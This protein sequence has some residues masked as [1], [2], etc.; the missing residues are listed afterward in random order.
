MYYSAFQHRNIKKV[1]HGTQKT[2]HR[3]KKAF[4]KGPAEKNAISK[5]AIW[6]LLI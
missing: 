4:K 5:I 6:A 1:F 3:K 2:E